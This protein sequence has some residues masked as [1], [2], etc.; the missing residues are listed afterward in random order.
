M[1]TLLEDNKGFVVYCYASRVG[2]GCVLMQHGKVVAYVSTQ[3]KV[4]EKHYQTDDVELK[5]MV[6]AFKILR[7]YLYGVHVD[8][9]TDHKSLQYVLTHK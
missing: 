3:H 2:L 5:A 7:N 9:Y 4:H 8:I 6:F 1:L